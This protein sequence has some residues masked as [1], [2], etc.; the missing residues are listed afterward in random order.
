MGN[1]TSASGLFTPNGTLQANSFLSLGNNSALTLAGGNLT[2]ADAIAGNEVEDN[3]LVESFGPG[4]GY[5]VT[6]AANAS[7]GTSSATVSATN[8]TS[9]ITLTG[10]TAYQAINSLTINA[11]VF[12]TGG[13]STSGLLVR[14]ATTLAG[15]TTLNVGGSN[16]LVLGGVVG[17]GDVTKIGAGTL[18]VTNTSTSTANTVTGWHVMAGTLESRANQGTA[19]DP[20]GSG[21][22]VQLDGGTL[23]L[24]DDGDDLADAE[25]IGAYANNSILVGSTTPLSSASFI[26]S[27]NSTL[28][29]AGINSTGEGRRT[30]RCRLGRCNS[31]ASWAAPNWRFKARIPI[32]W[33]SP[34]ASN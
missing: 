6:V 26:G 18:F 16:G 31:A 30:R 8:T 32:R 17:G 10:T 4:N 11:P 14:G 3:F 12:S 25:V 27:V 19:S 15:N 5:N 33:K 2:I 1:I 21:V 29:A 9:T 28:N 34:A 22:T 20:L 7:I 23:N 13:A 24:R